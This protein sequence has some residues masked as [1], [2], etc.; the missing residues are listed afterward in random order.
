ML[1][2]QPRIHQ[3]HCGAL[4]TRCNSCT[5]DPNN[6][7]RSDD[8]KEFGDLKGTTG[9]RNIPGHFTGQRSN[10]RMESA[11]PHQGTRTRSIHPPEHPSDAFTV[12][13][14]QRQTS[15]SRTRIEI[16]ARCRKTRKNTHYQLTYYYSKTP[17]LSEP[18]HTLQPGLGTLDG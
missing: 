16:E 14:Q 11:P 2:L 8:T 10:R 13:H 5:V 7:E 17:L 3:T 15:R 9:M 6:E 12:E 1:I 4:S 18:L